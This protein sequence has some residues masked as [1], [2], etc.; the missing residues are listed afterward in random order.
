MV[1]CVH[2]VPGRARFKFDAL[3][4]DSGVAD[5]VRSEIGAVPGV[6]GVEVNR[7]AASVIVHYCTERGEIDRVM[8][9]IRA[10]CPK[11]SA[12]PDGL[13][14]VPA[15]RTA[16]P[17]IDLPVFAPRVTSAVGEAVG[18]AVVN[19]FINRAVERGLSSVFLGLR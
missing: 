2:H 11:A 16:P 8:E 1:A 7:Y 18:K 6:V 4:S 12:T 5:R 19:T 10:H 17:R 13:P 9:R 15:P 14:P 3:R